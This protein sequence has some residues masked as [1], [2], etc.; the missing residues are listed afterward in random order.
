MAERTT[1]IFQIPHNDAADCSFSHVENT[2]IVLHDCAVDVDDNC[3][4]VR[5]RDKN[6]QWVFSF[7]GL[8]LPFSDVSSLRTNIYST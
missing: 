6:L 2:R 1:M 3:S 8:S 5:V 4:L 7:S